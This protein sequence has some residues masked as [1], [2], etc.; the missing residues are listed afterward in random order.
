[1]TWRASRE[2]WSEGEP[3]TRCS[4]P[5]PHTC[6]GEAA[7]QPSQA[8]LYAEDPSAQVSC[9]VA[10]CPLFQVSCTC[11]GMGEQWWGKGDTWGRGE[12]N[13]TPTPHLC[14]EMRG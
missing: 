11:V 9:R 6:P 14:W 13:A 12:A 2:A 4:G 3:H 7:R 5:A 8:V 10:G 1:M